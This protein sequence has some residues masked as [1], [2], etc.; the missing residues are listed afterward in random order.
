MCSV[1]SVTQSVILSARTL[2]ITI[3]GLLVMDN[4]QYAYI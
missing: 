3:Q 1:V 2:Y 4:K